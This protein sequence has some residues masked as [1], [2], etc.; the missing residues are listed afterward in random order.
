[1]NGCVKP[2][3]EKVSYELMHKTYLFAVVTIQPKEQLLR[4]IT[5]YGST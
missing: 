3:L 4:E 5:L 2:K 1:M